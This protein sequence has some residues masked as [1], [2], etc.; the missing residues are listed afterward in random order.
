[1]VAIAC[2]FFTFSARGHQGEAAQQGGAGESSTAVGAAG[3]AAAG[4]AEQQGPAAGSWDA[5]SP[6]RSTDGSGD[7]VGMADGGE[8]EEGEAE[9]VLTAAAVAGGPTA[10]GGR[11]SRAQAAGGAADRETVV[12]LL[13]PAAARE[14]QEAE[15]RSCGPAGAP[16]RVLVFGSEEEMMLSWAHCLR[17]ADPDAIGL[18]QASSLRFRWVCLYGGLGVGEQGPLVHCSCSQ[19]DR[20]PCPPLN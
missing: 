9:A 19:E 6:D 1:M 2:T 8:E 18:F 5:A 4:A 11:R 13:H 12:F 7:A 14:R 17:L 3:A 16:A 10:A 15:E 20:K